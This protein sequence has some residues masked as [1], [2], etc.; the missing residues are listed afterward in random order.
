MHKLFSDWK[1]HYGVLP[2]NKPMKTKVS[3]QEKINIGFYDPTYN[4]Y[5]FV[6]TDYI[7]H[8]YQKTCL[9]HYHD[10]KLITFHMNA[11]IFAA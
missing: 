2:F 3:L 7:L 8:A 6:S 9:N 11:V 5:V 1:T 4:V 10:Y